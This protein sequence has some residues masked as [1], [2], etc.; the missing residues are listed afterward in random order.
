VKAG[1]RRPRRLARPLEKTEP[2]PTVEEIVRNF[3]VRQPV[4]WV[5]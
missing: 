4:L 2:D 3:S 5:K 1:R